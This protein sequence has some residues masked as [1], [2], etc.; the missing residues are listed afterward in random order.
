MT[1]KTA[2]KY[3]HSGEPPSAQIK[4]RDWQT[5]VNPFEA[6]WLD[7]EAKL[8]SS[9]FIADRFIDHREHLGEPVH[10]VAHRLSADR[11]SEPGF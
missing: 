3:I 10:P 5:R 8:Q 11:D 7:V 6:I 1:P 4:E 9:D 2:S